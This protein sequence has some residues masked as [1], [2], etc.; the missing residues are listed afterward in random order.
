MLAQSRMLDYDWQG[1][2]AEYLRATRDVP[3]SPAPHLEYAELLACLGR[4]AEA[5]MA[6]ERGLELAGEP[7]ESATLEQAG[8]DCFALGRVQEALRMFQRAIDASPRIRLAYW[9]SAVCHWKLGG[10]DDALSALDKAEDANVG[11]HQARKL[12]LTMY[13]L[14][15]KGMLYAGIGDLAEARR[16]L[17]RIRSFPD[18]LIDR[19]L[20]A[21]AVLFHMGEVDEGLLWLQRSVDAH[22]MCLRRCA[23]F[24]LPMD[25]VNDAR[26]AAIYR[27]AGLPIEPLREPA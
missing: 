14:C 23:Y 7:C 22:D 27:K 2:E 18:D 3:M 15:I 9:W 17:E 5:A 26:F 12:Y 11:F 25:V 8:I 6:L 1:A 21:A 13:I 24:D 19:S 4:R 16:C 20:T 10:Y